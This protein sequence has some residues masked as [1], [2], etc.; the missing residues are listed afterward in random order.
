M[1]KLSEAKRLRAIRA[2]QTY[3]NAL[4]A[5]HEDSFQMDDM[6]AGCSVQQLQLATNVEIEITEDIIN[7]LKHIRM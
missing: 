1:C 2:Y 5:A 7:E 4:K 6:D 3:L